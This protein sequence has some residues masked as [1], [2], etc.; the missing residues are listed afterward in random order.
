MTK[1]MFEAQLP[2][3]SKDSLVLICGPD[4]LINDTVKPI[5]VS[6]TVLAPRPDT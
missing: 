6:D 1:R 2:A 3:A 5:L 4:P